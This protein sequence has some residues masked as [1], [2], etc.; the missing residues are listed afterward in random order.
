MPA[1]E[2]LTE[3]IFMKHF[4]NWFQNGPDQVLYFVTL[5][6]LSGLKEVVMS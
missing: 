4:I 3:Y 5:K 6:D 1:S 2:D